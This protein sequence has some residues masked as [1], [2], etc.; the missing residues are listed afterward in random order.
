MMS[1]RYFKLLVVFLGLF[2]MIASIAEGK[3]RHKNGG[4]SRKKTNTVNNGGNNGGKPKVPMCGTTAATCS[5]GSPSC[6]GGKPTCGSKGAFNACG[7]N[8]KVTC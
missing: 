8:V 2:A 4:G 5:K 6:K 1:Q 3:G 7:G